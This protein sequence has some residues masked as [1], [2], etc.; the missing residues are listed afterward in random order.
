MLIARRKFLQFLSCV[1][2]PKVHNV[3]NVHFPRQVSRVVPIAL[4]KLFVRSRCADVE[5]RNIERD[6]E[7]LKGS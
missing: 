6:A 7:G 1:P 3:H 2:A 5:Q 4:A